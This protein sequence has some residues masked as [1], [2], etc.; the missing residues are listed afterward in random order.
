MRRGGRGSRSQ[1]PC[2]RWP[3]AAATETRQRPTSRGCPGARRAPR[4]RE[5]GRRRQARRG[6]SVR[7]RPAG[8]RPRGRRRAG[9]RRGNVPDPFQAELTAAA[10]KAAER[11]QLSASR[12]S[13][14]RKR[15]TA[16]S[17]R[18]KQSLEAQKEEAEGDEAKELDQRIKEL[19]R[20][21]KECGKDNGKG[22]E[23][24]ARERMSVQTLAA[25]RY[26]AS[27]RSGRAAWRPSTWRTTRTRPLGRDQGPRRASVERRGVPS[28]IRPRSTHGGGALAPKHRPRL[29][30]G[31]RGRS[32]FH[33]DGVRG[34]P[35]ARR[36]SSAQVLFR[37][38]VVDLALQ[39]CGG[40][41]HAHASGLVHRDIKPGNLLLSENG[42]VKIAGLRDRARGASDE[43][44]AD[45]Q[46]PRHRGIPRAGASG[47]P[48]TAAA[49]IYSLGCV[50]FSS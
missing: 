5:R 12:A 20:Q 21:L 1:A 27:G 46:H 15:S 7:S 8:R 35:Y 24:A 25:G 42:T 36:G 34:R 18:D 28:A 43:A 41:E 31:R 30:P 13:A 2:S 37:P 11:R 10:K 44:H 17:S 40:L 14:P 3:P 9:D 50:L 29:R 4:Q 39:I 22:N 16:R 49:D 45:R 6:R 47:E 23:G 38:R 32:T 19:D 26:R 33:R 48:V